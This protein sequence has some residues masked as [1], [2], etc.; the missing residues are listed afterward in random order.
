[1]SLSSDRIECIAPVEIAGQRKTGVQVNINGA[2]SNVLNVDVVPTALGLLSSDQSGAGLAN[3]RNFDGT[4]NSATNPAPLGSIVTIFLT[5][6]GLTKPPEADGVPPPNSDIVPVA[7]ISSLFPVQGTLHALAGFVPGLF[8]YA[9]PI[10]ND[11][12]L[13]SVIRIVLS[14]DSSESQ[15]LF[16]YTR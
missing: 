1:M 9:L 16:V 7:T 11:P 2:T 3:A 8:A 12:R 5:G 15:N 10:P 4:L 6:V 14:T 13:T